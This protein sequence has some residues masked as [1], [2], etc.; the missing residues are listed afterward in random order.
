MIRAFF[1]AVL[2]AS[3]L[4]GAVGTALA[5]DV[6]VRGYTTRNGTYVQPH[7]RSSPDSNPNNNWSCCGNM[8]PHTGEM[9]TRQPRADVDSGLYRLNSGS[10]SSSPYSPYSR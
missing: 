3:L 9:G 4:A 7:W 8:N 10:R 5:G 2:G 1:S 6:F